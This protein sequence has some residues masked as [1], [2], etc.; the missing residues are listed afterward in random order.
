VLAWAEKYDKQLYREL[1]GNTKYAVSIFA[2]DRGGEKP[3][4]DIACYSEVKAYIS[5]FYDGLWDGQYDLPQNI[6]RG[7][8]KAVLAEYAKVFDAD[9]DKIPGL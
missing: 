7:D 9:D 2:I 8:I 4:K 6:S 1:C 5:Y 3:R